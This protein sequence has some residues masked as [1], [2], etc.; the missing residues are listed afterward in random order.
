M[1]HSSSPSDSF[2]PKHAN[3]VHESTVTVRYQ[4]ADIERA[5]SFYATHLGFRPAERYGDALASVRKGNLR[6][7]LSGPGSSGSRPMPDGRRGK[8]RGAGIEC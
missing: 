5:L 4:V 8:N 6:L 1:S 3:V 7:I 2:S